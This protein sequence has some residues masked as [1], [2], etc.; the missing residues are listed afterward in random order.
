MKIVDHQVAPNLDTQWKN[1]HMLV[2]S[3]WDATPTLS[4][5]QVN[6]PQKNW[7]STATKRLHFP[8]SKPVYIQKGFY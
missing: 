4:K 1:W 3:R 8:T 5:Q 2:V 6:H 7:L